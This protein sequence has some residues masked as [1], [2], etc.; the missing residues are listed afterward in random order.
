MT[1]SG[2]N[3]YLIRTSNLEASREF[4]QSVMG[5]HQIPRPNFPFPGYWLGVGGAAQVHLAPA[6]IE[7]SE[8]YFLGT[9]AHAAQDNSGVIDH[10]AFL[11][12]NAP[13]FV[14]GL[15]KKGA[16]YRVRYLSDSQLFQVFIKD[17][18][19]IT[20]ELNFNGVASDH[21]LGG[22]DYA[23]MVRVT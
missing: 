22:E 20:I 11:A 8:L 19:G 2:I 12:E 9:P 15:K 3:H 6:G 13:D 10:V 1:I 21:G 18:D 16:P 14:D 23:Q 4:Y 5:F 7:N 17:P